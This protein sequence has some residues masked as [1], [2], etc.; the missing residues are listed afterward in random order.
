MD[1]LD[2][3]K[4]DKQAP[5][6]QFLAA[7][8]SGEDVLTVDHLAVGYEATPVAQDLNLQVRRQEAIAL[9]G[10]NGVGKTTLL[11]TLIGQLPALAGTYRFGTGVQIGYYDQNLVLP[12]ENL[13]VLE[14]LWQAHDTTD[15]KV[16]RTILGSFLFSG[17]DV[18]KKVSM[19]SGGEKARLSLALLATEHD[20]T[21]ILD[22]PTNHLDIDSKE[23]LEDALIAFDGTLLFVSH[24]RYFINRLATQ[25]V[26]IT[27][28]GVKTYLGDY[29]YYQEKKAEEALIAQ[30]QA[31]E[32]STEPKATNS[33]NPAQQ[34]YQ[35]MKEAKRQR[36]R[37]EEAVDQADAS[38]AQWEARIAKLHAQMETAALANDQS[39]LAQLHQDLQEAEAAQLEALEA[40]ESASLALEDFLA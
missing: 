24:D 32:A 7:K 1:R 19:L 11:K 17:D 38:H 35:A 18:L 22:E 12:D 2:K 30:S 10:P 6:I 39:Q 27:P 34:D 31:S 37:L 29:D 36:R 28:Q 25:V 4:Q 5:R 13:T 26:E 21:L 23:V 20:N 14:T 9:V 15:E 40:W 16:I 3:P 33:A 8:D